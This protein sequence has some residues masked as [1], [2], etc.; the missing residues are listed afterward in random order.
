[1]KEYEYLKVYKFPCVFIS[2]TVGLFF[3][4]IFEDG[5]RTIY[6]YPTPD[7]VDTIQYKNATGTCFA[8]KQDK[9]T[10]PKDDIH[11]LKDDI[12]IFMNMNLYL[13]MRI[14]YEY[15]FFTICF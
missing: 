5:N 1:M 14:V 3:V 15:Y 7:N 10:C 2:L 6:I 13:I 4:Y 12:L 11:I 9:I 8:V